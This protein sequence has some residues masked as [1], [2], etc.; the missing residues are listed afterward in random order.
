MNDP[1]IEE[2]LRDHLKSRLNFINDRI[3]IIKNNSP[4]KKTLKELSK[5]KCQRSIAQERYCK[6]HDKLQI[7]KDL[8][9]KSPFLKVKQADKYLDHEEAEFRSPLSQINYKNP[10]FKEKID[11]Y[12]ILQTFINNNSPKQQIIRQQL[13]LPI[14]LKLKVETSP[15]PQKLT[16]I[17]NVR[18]STKFPPLY[19][20][21]KQRFF[22]LTSPPQS[23]RGQNMPSCKSIEKF[24]VLSIYKQVI[25][26]EQ[27][28]KKLHKKRSHNQKDLIN[29]LTP[30]KSLPDQNT[31]KTEAA[32]TDFLQINQI[33][34]NLNSVFNSKNKFIDPIVDHFPNNSNQ[35]ENNKNSYKF[36]TK[37]ALEPKLKESYN[38]INDGNFINLKKLNDVSLNV[39]NI[40]ASIFYNSTIS[41]PNTSRGEEEDN[42]GCMGQ[43]IKM[44]AS[45]NSKIG[46][47]AEPPDVIETPNNS[48]NDCSS[49][50]NTGSNSI[51]NIMHSLIERN[52]DS[53]KPE[54]SNNLT[55]LKNQGFLPFL[56]YHERNESSS[57]S[58]TKI[59]NNI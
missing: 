49:L 26:K 44:K 24:E 39:S 10:L 51:E 7:L 58:K 9:F 59:Y 21:K 57:R 34:V 15:S 43:K 18:S 41:I 19:L 28:S 6:D 45:T 54:S 35:R 20:E 11:P 14:P 38:K 12:Q 17:D 36:I 4:V 47:K 48:N 42:I 37:K 22:D 46:G 53:L 40:K 1:I 16:N 32:S 27:N 13:T 3:D 56:R 30:I 33:K 55:G 50:N 8:A 52:S 2:S 25:E 31:M 5:L 29:F 23:Q